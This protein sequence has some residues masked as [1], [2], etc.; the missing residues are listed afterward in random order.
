MRRRRRSNIFLQMRLHFFDY[1]KGYKYRRGRIYLYKYFN[2]V[3]LKRVNITNKL[4]P[5]PLK[6]NN[7]NKCLIKGEER[8]ALQYEVDS[9]RVRKTKSG[10]CSV[11]NIKLLL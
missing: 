11:P 2:S 9:E 7:S 8:W 4:P 5:H 6:N 1:I 10:W 3:S